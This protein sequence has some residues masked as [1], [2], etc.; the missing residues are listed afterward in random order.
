MAAGPY[1]QWFECML[2]SSAK[3]TTTEVTLKSMDPTPKVHA[4]DS[5]RSLIPVPWRHPAFNYHFAYTHYIAEYAPYSPDQDK[6]NIGTAC[7]LLTE[8]KG[9]KA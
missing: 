9:Y 8:V 5:S 7:P 6:Y 3:S 2:F 4:L 1:S